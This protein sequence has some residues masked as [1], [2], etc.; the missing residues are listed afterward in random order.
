MLDKKRTWVAKSIVAGLAWV[1]GTTGSNLQAQDTDALVATGLGYSPRQKDVDYDRVDTKDASKC[2]GKYET[3]SGVDGLMIYGPD[4]QL[5]RRFADIN[6]DRNVDLWCYYKD[7]IEV[8]RDIDSDFNGTADQYRWLGTQ[9]TRW[10]ID[11]NEDGTIDTW[12]SISAEEITMEVVEAVRN[13]DTKRFTRLLLTSDEIKSLQLGS[14]TQTRLTERIEK[15]KLGFSEFIEKQRLIDGESR[16][17]QFA[18]DKPGIIPDGTDG[19]TQ[20]LMAYENVIAIVEGK[21]S[22]QQLLIG[23]IVQVGSTWRLADAPRTVDS[24]SVTET[25]FFFPSLAA[26]REKIGRAHV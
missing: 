3:R 1:A 21:G 10:G 8:Y 16:W 5:L 22:S 9:G 12:K 13:K 24:S 14:D 26:N 11:K 18:A 6:G 4:G 19:S 20:D 17:A 7:G 15:S 25:G 2:T 23:T